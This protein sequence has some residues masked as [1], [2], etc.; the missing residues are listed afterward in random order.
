MGVNVLACLRRSKFWVEKVRKMPLPWNDLGLR[1]LY[2]F[3][4]T[5]GGTITAKP[6][7]GRLQESDQFPG[8]LT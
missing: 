6:I 5:K 2:L 8:K 7:M 3:S 4:W 1:K